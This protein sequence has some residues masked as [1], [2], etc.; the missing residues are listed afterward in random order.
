[1][2]REQKR[3]PDV[4]RIGRIKQSH[5]SNDE[6]TIAAGEG[7]SQGSGGEVESRG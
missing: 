5:I 6:A 7:A 1:M 3:G 4:V 2:G